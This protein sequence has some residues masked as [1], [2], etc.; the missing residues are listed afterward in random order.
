MTKHNLGCSLPHSW[1]LPYSRHCKRRFGWAGTAMRKH[2]PPSDDFTI[3]DFR[4]IR[5]VPVKTVNRKS[6]YLCIRS[7]LTIP[8]PLRISSGCVS[9]LIEHW[10]PL[11]WFHL[12]CAFPVCMW[13]HWLSTDCHSDNSISLVHFQDVREL[14][15]WTLTAP[16][17]IPPPLCISSGCVNLLIEHWLLLWWF[18]LPCAFP[19]G[20]WTCWFSTDCRSDDSISLVH[21]QDVCGF[22]DWALTAALMIP[23]PLCISSLYVD[24]LI[25]HWP[26]L[27]IPLPLC[28]SSW[29]VNL[30]I[31]HWLPLWQ[32]YLSCAFPVCMWTCWLSTDCHSDNSISLA[33]FQ[34]V[35]EL[36]DWALTATLTI[37]SLLC[38][39]RMY[40]NLLIEHWLLLW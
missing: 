2:A 16:L 33:H 14:V 39:S 30:L 13:T 12:P 27:M 6:W 5:V 24:L 11:W 3:A 40:V 32:F 31:E 4:N 38:I 29:C 9:L 36:V 8:S 26:T 7:I 22:V 20:V 35:R 10:L 37:P 23:F 28:I 21:F 18:H 25:E 34:T 17:M 1:C 19:V 15:D